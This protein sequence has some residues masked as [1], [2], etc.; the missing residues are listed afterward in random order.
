MFD[1]KTFLTENKL[2]L[3]EVTPSQA[4]AAKMGSAKLS[5]QQSIRA[6]N[7]GIALAKEQPVYHNARWEMVEFVERLQDI[8]RELEE[9]SKGL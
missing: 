7:Q 5:L 4:I 2:P 3:H 6:L 8:S 1:I 9:W